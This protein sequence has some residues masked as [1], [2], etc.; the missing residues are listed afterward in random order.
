[1]Y[2]SHISFVFRNDIGEKGRLNS[3]SCSDDRTFSFFKRYLPFAIKPGEDPG[4]GCWT[5]NLIAYLSFISP[6]KLNLIQDVPT[7]EVTDS[8]TKKIFFE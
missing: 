8:A 7:D 2:I 3:G 4:Q 1:M 6:A 5:F